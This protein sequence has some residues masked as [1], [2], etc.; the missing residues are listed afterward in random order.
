MVVE[1]PS[2]GQVDAAKALDNFKGFPYAAVNAITREVMNIE[3]RPFSTKGKE[4]TE[5]DSHNVLDLLD[6]VNDFQTGPELKYILSGASLAHRQCVLV[7][8]RCEE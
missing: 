1:A 8:G 4:P 7:F 3:F 5:L 6:S 2:G